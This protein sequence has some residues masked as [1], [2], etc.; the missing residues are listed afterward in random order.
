MSRS[1]GRGHGRCRTGCAVALALS[2]AVLCGPVQAFAQDLSHIPAAFVDVGTGA[3][4]M[5]MGGA[6]IVSSSGAPAVFWNPAGLAATEAATE[7]YVTYGDQMGLVPYSAASGVKRVGKRYSVGVGVIYSG[8]EVLSEMTGLLCAAGNF[9]GVPWMPEGTVLAGAAVRARWASFG[10]NPG[11]DARVTG[12]ALGAAV[13]AGVIVPLSASAR[14]G[15]AGRDL[16]GILNWDSSS[17]GSY[18][19]GVPPAL[20][21]G[22]AVELAESALVEVDLDKALRLDGRDLVSVGGE[23]E[24]FGVAALRAGYRVAL[25]PHEYEEFSLGGGAS[26]T[27]SR[28]EITLD[29][30]YV[31]G[32]LADTLRL[33]VRFAF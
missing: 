25:A 2:V 28:S 27:T 5:A 17:S 14:F 16:V 22:V 24:M 4:E 1:A 7:L 20:V 31:F 23:V 30:A 13:D 3:R 18:E 33:G 26:V 32:K 19:E 9:Q 12:S 29:V 10:N 15:V 8:D 6:A 11:S 21:F